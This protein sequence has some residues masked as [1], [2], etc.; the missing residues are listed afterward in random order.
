MKEGVPTHVLVIP[1][2]IFEILIDANHM[3]KKQRLKLRI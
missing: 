3:Q 1:Y 2:G